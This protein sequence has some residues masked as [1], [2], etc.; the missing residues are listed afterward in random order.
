MVELMGV[1]VFA[2]AGLIVGGAI[3][4]IVALFRIRALRHALEQTRSELNKVLER[5]Q[6]L[7]G[8]VSP[9]A[10]QAAMAPGVDVPCPEDSVAPIP[11]VTT[12]PAEHPVSEVTGP[13]RPVPSETGASGAGNA[14]GH[15]LDYLAWCGHF[16]GRGGLGPEI[17]L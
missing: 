13:S 7:A 4:G 5:F 6:T 15:A 1:V 9:A 16:S 2:M 10:G 17:Y 3:C 11:P 12:N 14:H 8:D